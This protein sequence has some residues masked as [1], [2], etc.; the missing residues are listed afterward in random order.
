MSH[1]WDALY[2]ISPSGSK[3]QRLVSAIDKLGAKADDAVF[4]ECATAPRARHPETTC[5]SHV[6][7]PRVR[8]L[9]AQLHRAPAVPA[10]G[11]DATPLL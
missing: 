3:L 2:H 5:P 1:G 4:I 7:L 10:A 8:I 11:R 9:S 6:W